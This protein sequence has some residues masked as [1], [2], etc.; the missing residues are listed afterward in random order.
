MKILVAGVGNE[1]RSDDGFAQEV[2]KRLGT[3]GKEVD[4]IDFGQ[5]VHELLLFIPDYR[6]VI[7][8]D[9]VDGDGRPGDIYVV[10]VDEEE[11]EDSTGLNAHDI[12]LKGIIDAGKKMGV[13]PERFVIV[14]CHPERTDPGIGLSETVMKRVD[15]AVD[16]IKK[17]IQEFLSL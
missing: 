6:A 3:Q 15:E 16:I 13:F 2:L 14:G 11:M 12:D 10:R 9:A 17:L 8:V 5:R 7:L 1:L 4:V